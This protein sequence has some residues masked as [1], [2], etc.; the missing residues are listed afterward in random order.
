VSISP[1]DGPSLAGAALATEAT[2]TG[3]G[4][5]DYARADRRWS[6]GATGA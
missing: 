5:A 3:A 6:G 4:A 2:D 1:I